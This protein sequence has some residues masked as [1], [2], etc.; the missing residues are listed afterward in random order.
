MK[1]KST[2]YKNGGTSKNEWVADKVSKLILEGNSLE[3]SQAIAN[4]IYNSGD[5]LYQN[6]GDIAYNDKTSKLRDID[7]IETGVY[8]T[9]MGKGM[10]VFT[11][12]GDREFVTDEAYKNQ[13]QNT[14]QLK[15]YLNLSG[16]LNRPI[17][18]IED[19]TY[20]PKNINPNDVIDSKILPIDF[21]QSGVTNDKMG[22][23]YYFKYA[24]GL[25]DFVTEEGYNASKNDNSVRK[26]INTTGGVDRAVK[27]TENKIY[28]PRMQNGGNYY[29][30]NN[31]YFMQNPGQV[32]PQNLEDESYV[33]PNLDGQPDPMGLAQ[34][35]KATFFNPYGGF[36]IPSA[37]FKLGQ[38][39]ESGNGFDIAAGGLKLL[40][41]LGRNVASGMG[42]QNRRE[43]VLDEYGNKV[44][45]GSRPMADQQQYGGYFQDG[46]QMG[47]QAPPQEAG[48]DMISQV[49][50]AIQ[51]G[52]NPQE[53]LQQLVQN[54]VPQE[55]AVS[56]IES[57]MQQIQPQMQN[58]GLKKKVIGEH[59]YQIEGEHVTEIE[60][61]EFIKKPNGDIREGVGEKH[62]QGGI[63][64]TEEQL[65]DGSK[66][67]SDHLEVGRD[68]AKRF[69]KDYDL[70]IKATDTYATV[71]DKFNRKSGIKKIVDEQAEVQK[72][73]EKQALKLEQNPEAESTLALNLQLFTDQFQEL[74]DEKA[75]LEEAR[76]IL[77]DEVFQ[78][79][80][81]SKEQGE[82]NYLEAQ[83]PIPGGE[84][85]E[86]KHGGEKNSLW[87]NI[88][89]NRGSGKAPT[90]EMLEQ[91]AK[92]KRAQMGGEYNEGMIMEYSTKHNLHPDRVR[93]LMQVHQN[94]GLQQY[95]NG[96]FKVS[97][98][99]NVNSKNKRDRQS[100]NED[101]YGITKSEQAL[102]QLYNN[103]PDIINS[104]VT[105]KKYL[106]VGDNGVVKFK[107][108]V[109][110]NKQASIVGNAQKLMDERMVDSANTIMNNPSQFSEEAT[111]EAQRYLTD[112][113]FLANAESEKDATRSIRGYDNKLGDFTSGR[114]S[115]QMNLVTPEERKMLNDAGVQ[116]VKQLKSS[117]LR[118]KLSPESLSNV[119][120]VDTL[121]GDTNADYG[122]AEITPQKKALQTE[123]AT[124][125]FAK[126]Q[127]VPSG[128]NGRTNYQLANLPD[129]SPLLPDSL[130]GALKLNTRYDRIETPFVSPDAQIR[131]IR[132]QE[133]S[134]IQ[135][136]QSLPDSQKATATAQIQANSQ[137]AIN[138]AI[139]QTQGANQQAKF[140]ADVTNAQI[141]MKEEDM[142]NNNLQNYENKITK[143]DTLTQAN[144]RNYYNANQKVNVGNYNFIQGLNLVNDRY[145]NAQY[146][147]QNTDMVNLEKAK[148]YDASLNM[149]QA[150]KDLQLQKDYKEFQKRNRLAISPK[151][152][153][154][155]KK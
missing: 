134:A 5:K 144:L 62:N 112:E 146:N 42:V 12:D 150:E 81:K 61:G 152:R 151:K 130:Q 44:R 102:Q 86:F 136:L 69:N 125:P 52:A 77:F 142:R 32:L 57:I 143:A 155:G 147:G 127:Y 88:R 113:T 22:K 55:E 51:Q 103:F 78:P 19:K 10:Y 117:P 139:G 79:Q 138:Q 96:A 8:N 68:G 141:Q 13:M 153:F 17:P 123:K 108:G 60:K 80:E 72:N 126:S 131:E 71:L 148:M 59:E 29:D 107:G 40:T 115:M 89:N 63:K 114:Y 3:K 48:Q 27:G 154:G 149:S 111:I 9:S 6:G 87:K 39:I 47:Q 135:N 104:D 65:P 105:F 91:E 82:H 28:R 95:Q 137:N 58:G 120:K 124:I 92:I 75:P 54:G 25:R 2:R 70:N 14:N 1:K 76:K 110:L 98:N 64:L 26:Y 140:N 35:Q 38:G 36:D 73:I 99:T 41:G 84:D 56:M 74:Q 23:G 116:T 129:Q 53:I 46:G 97:N 133:Q 101:A 83:K 20:A 121:I 34:N 118:Q 43:W 132:R 100:P 31:P 37:A 16:G 119:D 24:N 94:G 30:N 122:I 11:K 49:V 145:D 50:E 106:E 45:E 128:E 4:A 85:E 66:I 90:K 15:E 7:K 21:I 18:N 67:I 93:E 33:D 109:P